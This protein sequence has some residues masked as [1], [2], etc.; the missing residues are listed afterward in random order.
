MN[1]VETIRLPLIGVRKP[2]A[3]QNGLNALLLENEVK[4][5]IVGQSRIN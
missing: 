3:F 4:I 5:E 1:L 2:F